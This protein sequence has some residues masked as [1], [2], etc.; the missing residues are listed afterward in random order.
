MT[1]TEET[2]LEKSLKTMNDEQREY[3]LFLNLYSIEDN[4]KRR[5]IYNELVKK[6]SYNDIKIYLLASYLADY[7]KFYKKCTN[8]NELNIANQEYKIILQKTKQLAQE[9]NLQ[10]SLEIA[11]LYTYLLYNGYFSKN[12]S[13]SYGTGNNDSI[14]KHFALDIMNGSGVCLNFG[15]MLTDFINEFDYSAA[16]LIN[17]YDAIVNMDNI[18]EP[19]LKTESMSLKKNFLH[20]ILT[21][22]QNITGNHLFTLIK[23][24]DKIYIYDATNFI[25]LDIKDRFNCDN[26]CGNGSCKIKPY[27]SHSNNNSDKAL[28]TLQYLNMGTSFTSPYDKKKFICTWEVCHEKFSNNS[29]LL[30]CFYDEIKSNIENIN[31]NLPIIK[32]IIREREKEYI[33]RKK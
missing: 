8:I 13:L 16:N 25:I 24:N 5:N 21:P 23:E 12:H 32:K 33:K 9:L 31:A 28:K 14:E 17:K 11:N 2:E 7:N 4:E 1:N 18:Q 30:N 26:I 10:N 20:K 29:L 22:F 6:K 27:Y 19:A 15:D 3:I